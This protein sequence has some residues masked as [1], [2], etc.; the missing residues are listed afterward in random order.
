M[1]VSC[2]RV[3]AQT[4]ETGPGQFHIRGSIGVVGRPSLMR[5]LATAMAVKFS[6]SVVIRV[7][8]RCTNMLVC[9]HCTFYPCAS[10][11]DSYRRPR[12]G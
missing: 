3:Q 2:L 7:F 4:R 11:S 10:T 8:L 5:M 9:T 1:S 6:Y 12:A